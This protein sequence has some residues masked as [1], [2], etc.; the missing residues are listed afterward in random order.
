LDRKGA[1]E[2]VTGFLTNTLLTED[3]NL[4]PLLDKDHDAILAC[5][6]KSLGSS[7][8]TNYKHQNTV[9]RHVTNNEIVSLVSLEAWFVRITEKMKVKCF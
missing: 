9:Y 5:I 7:L 8:F 3:V 4:S 1:V 2:S 6:K